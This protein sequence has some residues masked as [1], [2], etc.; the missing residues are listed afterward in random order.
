MIGRVLRP[1]G[2][3]CGLVAFLLCQFST[4][5]AF[6]AAL[7]LTREDEPLRDRLAQASLVL[8]AKREEVTAPLD[9]L[10]AAQADYGNLVS[11][12]Y[13][14]GYFGPVVKILVDGREAAS[15]PPLARLRSVRRVLILIDTGPPF[16]LGRARIGP[17]DPD[18]ELPE[19]FAPGEP[20]N[21][22]VIADA[23]EAGIDAWRARSFAKARVAREN[24]TADHAKAQL[25]VDLRLDPG[26][27]ATFGKVNVPKDSTVRKDRIR[28]IAGIP[29]GK[30]FDPVELERAAKRLRRTGAFSAVTIREAEEL[31]PDDTLDIDLELTDAKPRRFGFGAE[32]ESI[33]GLTL[34]GYWMHRNLFGGAERFR[35]EAE[36]AGLGGD[37]EG[38]D[39]TLSISL[40]RPSTF[41]SDTDL[42]ALIELEQ[43]DEELFNSEQ[44]TVG[45]G[46]SH[47]YSDELE[48]RIGLAYRF[49]D[50]QDQF[51]SRTFS[52]LTVPIEL[53]WDKRDSELDA[54]EGFFLSAE[55]LPFY[56]LDGSESGARGYLD[57]RGYRELGDSEIVLA[58]RLQ[59]GSII[60]SS[61]A[62]TPPDLLFL[63]GGSG[64]VRGQGYQS[65]SVLT[66]AVRTGGR[67]FIGL[68]GE[69]RFPVSRKLGGVVFYD[70]GYIGRNSFPDDT[71]DWHSGAGLGVRY[72][73]AFGPIRFDV[74]VPVSGPETSGFEF[75]IG[76]GQA[77]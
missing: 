14:Q 9:I 32:I 12:L 31:N 68:A 48:G 20:A 76:I 61:L 51:G 60:G 45:A 3:R 70:V 15:I 62:G 40:T 22:G 72:K 11:R 23:A 75:Y 52:H 56:G 37:T 2:L 19:E 36:I 13:A 30:P 54:T 8:T 64:T 29:R 50:V 39:T 38:V 66:G 5:W 69:A 74:A 53:T 71:G 49:S 34:S 47:Y 26:R 17:L 16:Q 63:S 42:Y 44:I 21:V 6:E 1:G 41:D 43:L 67:S 18:T 28:R 10:A 46:I 65:L 25:N 58:T 7:Q 33:E 55:A 35:V 59:F 57:A 73:T 77:F 4:A 24:I 27:P